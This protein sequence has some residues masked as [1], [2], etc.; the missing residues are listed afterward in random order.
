MLKPAA[1]NGAGQLYLYPRTQQRVSIKT[2]AT[3]VSISLLVLGLGC[4]QNLNRYIGRIKVSEQN[5]HANMG[6][7]I[8]IL[9]EDGVEKD[10][11]VHRGAN[12]FTSFISYGPAR[13][14]STLQFNIV[15]VCFFLHM[16][17]HKPTLANSTKCYYQSKTNYNY[18]SLDLPQVMKTHNVKH[19]SDFGAKSGT[20]I[21]ITART[22]E[23]GQ[24]M[25]DNLTES[26]R[27]VGLIQDLETLSEIKV[28]GFLDMYADFFDLPSHY[29][30]ML[31][32]HYILWEKLRICCGRQMS[33][34]WRYELNAST[35]EEALDPHPFCGSLD[36]DAVEKAFMNTTIF[37]MIDSHGPQGMN[38]PAM[39]DDALDGTYC[40]R[41]NKAVQ[42][43]GLEFNEKLS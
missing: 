25:A 29:L 41:Y 31:H 38:K 37:K 9:E 21:F 3:F 11:A 2:V 7:N 26:G 5:T 27:I 20:G 28:D 24:K 34:Y 19:L 18:P 43:E 16:K 32:E 33:K 12:N 4:I 13:S 39:R 10:I 14:A 17:V 30:P 15:C 1:K 36:I 22:K 35:W 8:S 42:A 23:Q 40:S 6:V